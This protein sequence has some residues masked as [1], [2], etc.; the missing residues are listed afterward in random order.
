MGRRNLNRFGKKS[1][2]SKVSMIAWIGEQM[3]DSTYCNKSKRVG[4]N[5]LFYVSMPDW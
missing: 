5:W 1:V 3:K 2:E 4:N